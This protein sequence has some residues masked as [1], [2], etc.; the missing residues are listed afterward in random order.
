MSFDALQQ[1]ITESSGEIGFP[2]QP[3]GECIDSKLAV[4]PSFRYFAATL[5]ESTVTIIIPDS[6]R[7]K[8][9]SI[10]AQP[11]RKI[12]LRNKDGKR[13]QTT[14]DLIFQ[15]PHDYINIRCSV[16]SAHI[17]AVCT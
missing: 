12:A 4:D 6:H 7:T 3:H 13:R 11:L 14:Q 15:H 2:G 5:Y 17:V 9:H 10:P 16:F 8:D 1:I